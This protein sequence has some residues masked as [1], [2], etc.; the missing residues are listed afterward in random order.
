MITS[1]ADSLLYMGDAMHHYVVSVQKPEWFNG[2]DSDQATA[3]A[4][5]EALL[6]QSAA[7]GQRIYAVHFPFPGLGRFEKTEAGYRWIPE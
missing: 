6:A 5:R 7:S 1:G 4:S 3:A 2:Y